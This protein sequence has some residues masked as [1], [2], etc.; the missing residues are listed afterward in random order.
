MAVKLN[1]S[2]IGKW[3]SECLLIVI[4]VLMAFLIEEKRQVT[5]RKDT[6]ATLLNDLQ[7]SFT[8]D[9]FKINL[10]I[11]S[12]VYLDSVN[13]VIQLTHDAN[14]TS[15]YIMNL[16][17]YN[18]VSNYTLERTLNDPN[19]G[20]T[21]ASYR[22]AIHNYNRWL[23]YVDEY[24]EKRYDTNCQLLEDLI[25]ENGNQFQLTAAF[26]GLLQKNRDLISELIKYHQSSLDDVNELKI[27]TQK[28][29]ALLK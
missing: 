17:V 15:D 23:T 21:S 12:L 22:Q 2:K 8:E 29:I 6:L 27:L 26:R 7:S 25:Y 28:E 3:L 20:L 4:S 10:R 24:Y 14:Q 9:S 13:E 18:V 11:K 5:N 1:Y 19:L 16:D